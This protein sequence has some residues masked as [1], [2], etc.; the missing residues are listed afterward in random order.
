MSVLQRYSGCTKDCPNR[1]P[2]CQTEACPVYAE[3][4][5]NIETIKRARESTYKDTMTKR[6]AAMMINRRKSR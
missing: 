4:K 3:F 5:R 2:G 1:K 6:T